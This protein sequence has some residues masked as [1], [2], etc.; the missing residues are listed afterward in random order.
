MFWPILLKELITRTVSPLSFE[1]EKSMN[2][3]FAFALLLLVLVPL[4]IVAQ[5]PKERK[6]R[7]LEEQERMAVLK[8]D[9]PALEKLWSKQFIV[10]NPQN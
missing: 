6:I 4:T 5:E 10:N 3:L 7:A 2:R 9:I 8:E 1:V